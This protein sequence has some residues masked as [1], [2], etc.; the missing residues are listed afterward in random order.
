MGFHLDKTRPAQWPVIDNSASAQS[1]PGRILAA[2][3]GAKD[4]GFA[5][6]TRVALYLCD[7]DHSLGLDAQLPPISSPAKVFRTNTTESTVDAFT[8]PEWSSS[9]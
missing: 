1:G 6:D 8:A 2:R 7:Y 5:L 4:R 3:S 9:G